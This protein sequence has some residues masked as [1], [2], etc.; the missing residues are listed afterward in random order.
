MSLAHVGTIFHLLCIF[1]FQ[2]YKQPTI[3]FNITYNIQ[4]SSKISHFSKMTR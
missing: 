2:K 4:T 1:Y 3:S